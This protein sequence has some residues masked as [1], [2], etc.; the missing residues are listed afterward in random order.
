MRQGALEKR[1][2]TMRVGVNY[3]WAWNAYGTYF[4]A[5][6]PPGSR[7]ELDRWTS[8]FD[9]NLA[10]LR[11]VGVEVVRLFL[12]CNAHNYGAHRGGR[13]EHPAALHPRFT[14]HLA[15]AL[16]SCRRRGVQL[17]PSLLDFK[18]LGR[19]FGAN[20]CTGRAC[21][22]RTEF[23]R[24]TFLERAL[25]PLVEV[26]AAERAA[27]HAF[28]VMSE[29]TWNLRRVSAP[30]SAAGGRTLTDVEMTEFLEGA[31]QRIEAAALPSTVGHRFASDLDRFP[32]GT[33][34]QFHYYPERALGVTF[35]DRA[36]APH[37]VTRA[38]VGEFGVR[39]PG[40]GQGALWPA[41]G[42]RDAGD[43]R[44]R[45]RA[46]LEHLAS[47]GYPLAL[48]WPDGTDGRGGHAPVGGLD[49]L[50]FS[51]G[52]LAGVADFTRGALGHIDREQAFSG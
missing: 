38:F 43:T 13:F 50:Q 34:R 28:E 41:L 5:G 39:A 14:E 23:D 7:P 52:A 33:L 16:A 26:C 31:L 19:A 27:L 21:L 9:Q 44:T 8:D 42:G 30:L 36:L 4:G 17:L 20:G 18:A 35:V 37:A 49:E 40:E 12:F 25:T 1:A 15:L 47:L 6:A 2:S 11:D 32:T 22:A 24:E 10:R 51:V 45:T 29:P 3:P 46:R 48:L